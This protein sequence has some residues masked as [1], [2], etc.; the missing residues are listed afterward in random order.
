MTMLQSRADTLGSYL[1]F[2]VGGQLFGLP[3]RE[4]R[5]VVDLLPLTRLPECPP[6]VHGVV[7]LR[8]Q[9][10]L[11]VDLAAR[12]GLPGR[13]AGRRSCILV[14]DRV[15][16]VGGRPLGLLVDS[17][18]QLLELTENERTPLGDRPLPHGLRRDLV[19]GLAG[20][21]GEAVL[22]LDLECLLGPVA[23][24]RSGQ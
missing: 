11:V 15:A 8:G 9:A 6:F 7:S 12:M 19:A 23:Q 21:A 13:P 22:L 2:G 18:Q 20:G 4:V 5:E 24:T 10:V 17:A 3:V 1:C 16:P 14:L